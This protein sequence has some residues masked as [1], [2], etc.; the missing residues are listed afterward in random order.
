[1]KKVYLI[2]IVAL[3]LLILNFIPLVLIDDDSHSKIELFDSS[4]VKIN[5]VYKLVDVVDSIAFSQKCIPHS[6]EY[7]EIVTNLIK[8]RFRH[9]Y[10]HYA[11]NENWIVSLLGYFVWK[12]I[13]AIVIP[14]DILKYPN[15]AC[16]QQSIVMMEVLKMKGIPFRKVTWDHHFTI[17]AWVDNVWYF[18]DPNMEPN[19]TLNER[20][21]DK[22]FNSLSFLQSKYQK[23]LTPTQVENIFGKP[24]VGTINHYPAQ[25]IYIFHVITFWISKTLWFF[26]L[27]YSIFLYMKLKRRD[28]F[29]THKI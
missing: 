9:G 12:D 5:S 22:R 4:L 19:L 27:A 11:L 23:R 16:S 15:A 26:V 24:K 21:F 3:F 20:K 7:N 25:K 1:M 18:Y 28:S 17:C 6:L 13:S 8:Y 29:I 10:S 2:S 14:D